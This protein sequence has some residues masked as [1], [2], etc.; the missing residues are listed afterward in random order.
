MSDRMLRWQQIAAMKDLSG[1][2]NAKV[3]MLGGP[4]ASQCPPTRGEPGRRH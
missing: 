4:V 2:P 3:I 1:S